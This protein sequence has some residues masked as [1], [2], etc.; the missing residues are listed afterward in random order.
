MGLKGGLDAALAGSLPVLLPGLF[1]KSA[2]VAQH[3]ATGAPTLALR[4]L[5]HALSNMLE[6]VLFAT[7]DLKFFSRQYPA[8]SIAV[9]FL[10][11]KQRASAA[12]PTL[13]DVWGSFVVYQVPAAPSAASAALNQREPRAPKAPQQPELTTTIGDEEP[14]TSR[15]P[16]A[17][18][19]RRRWWRSRRR[20]RRRRRTPSS[21]SSS[22][23]IRRGGEYGRAPLCSEGCREG[24]SRPCAHPS[25]QSIGST[26]AHDLLITYR[27]AVVSTM[28]KG[29]AGAGE[30][31]RKKRKRKKKNF[32]T[33]QGLRNGGIRVKPII[34]QKQEKKSRSM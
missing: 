2:A 11:A 13:S 25:T 16:C 10:F 33:V 9:F 28:L 31:T 30:E 19:S 21:S 17:P 34:I 15:P 7:G 32:A 20:R 6:G 1:T 14:G 24:S 22:L 4:L 27:R 23:W 5:L 3:M 18:W 8:S 12:A 29:A 26:H